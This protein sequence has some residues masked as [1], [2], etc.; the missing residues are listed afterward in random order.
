MGEIYKLT[1]EQLNE[2]LARVISFRLEFEKNKSFASLQLYIMLLYEFAEMYAVNGLDIQAKLGRAK[3]FY[4]N[5]ELIRKLFVIRGK[6]VHRN[7]VVTFEYLL[8]FYKTNLETIIKLEQFLQDSLK[9][10]GNN[11]ERSTDT[12]ECI[13]AF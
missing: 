5:P 7:Y 10:K 11:A 8:T 9:S 1:L 6:I 2:Y 3:E 4:D 13:S 12:V